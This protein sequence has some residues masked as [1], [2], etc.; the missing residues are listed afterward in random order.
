MKEI[1]KQLAELLFDRGNTMPVNLLRKARALH[2]AIPLIAQSLVENLGTKIRVRTQASA[3]GCTDGKTIWLMQGVMPTS[4]A[5]EDRYLV[6]TALKVGLVHHEVGHVNETDFRVP[7]PKDPLERH[8]YNIIEDVRQE[9]AHIRRH[10]AGRKYLDALSLASIITGLNGY[11]AD[12]CSQPQLFTSYLLYTLRTQY[13]QEPHFAVF[14]EHARDKVKESYGQDVVVRLEAMF[15]RTATLRSSE[16]AIVLAGDIT[17]LIKEEVKKAEQQQQSADSNQGTQSDQDDDST[18]APGTQSQSPDDAQPDQSGDGEQGDDQDNDGGSSP[19]PSQ[20]QG[21]ND[22]GASD[23]SPANSGGNGSKPDSDEPVLIDEQVQNLKDLLTADASDAIGSLDQRVREQIMQLQDD[24]VRNDH[25]EYDEIDMDAIEQALSKEA[26]HLVLDQTEASFA[27]AESTVG[28]ISSRLKQR[29][30]ANSMTKT[31]RSTT[32]SK[33]SVKNL[34]GIA[35]GDAR[36]FR[37][38]SSG[39]DTDTAVFLLADVSSSMRGSGAENTPIALSN[40]AL[41]A[42]ALALQRIPGVDVAVGAFPSNQMVLRFGERARPN[43]S[44]FNL[45]A[46]DCTPLAQGLTMATTALLANRKP[47]KLLM[48]LTD[49]E[50]DSRTCAQAAIDHAIDSGIEVYGLG[51]MTDVVQHLFEDWASVYDITELPNAV[52]SMLSTRI[53]GR[54]AA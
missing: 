22:D 2:R 10:K 24:I 18:T 1:K 25:C 14:A 33:I 13:R 36:I 11:V 9:N 42:S 26:Q 28:R 37:K 6:Y 27:Q 51:V 47:R 17:F 44:R 34:P 53:T 48:V 50:P 35:I 31:A 19:S 45:S 41:Y 15:P 12:G 30:Q 40:Q 21:E 3:G 38:I 49:G 7:M 4:S 39:I 46:H 52:L 54:K 32:G 20:D 8:I 23:Q 5:D 43:Q 16:E 29:L